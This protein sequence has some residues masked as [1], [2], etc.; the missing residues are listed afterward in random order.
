LAN[1]SRG[2]TVGT[3]SGTHTIWRHG[4]HANTLP[5]FVG[6]NCS[7]FLACGAQEVVVMVSTHVLMQSRGVRIGPRSLAKMGKNAWSIGSLHPIIDHPAIFAGGAES[8][9]GSKS[10]ASHAL[11]LFSV[12]RGCIKALDASWRIGRHA[13]M[14]TSMPFSA[15]KSTVRWCI[16][17]NQAACSLRFSRMKPDTISGM[18]SMSTR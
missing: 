12:I 8:I 2:I 6:C 18:L 3:G 1:H 7:V 11:T 14:R 10:I 9:D 17:E 16:M 13:D 4:F 5:G 15:I